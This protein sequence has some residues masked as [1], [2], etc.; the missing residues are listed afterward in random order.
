MVP[1]VDV[2]ALQ[3]ETTGEEAVVKIRE[4]GYSRVILTKGRS[5]D[6][7]AGYLYAKDFLAD[8]DAPKLPNLW[9]MRRDI[10]FVPETM[11]LLDLMREMQKQQTPIAVVVDE[12]GGSSGIVSME[13]L[14]E[15][16]VGEIRDEMDEE[17]ATRISKVQGAESTWDVD[18]RAQMQDLR[19][20]GVQVDDEE[21]PETVGTVVLARLGRLPRRG[22][23]VNL[24]SDATAEVTS[25]SRR[26]V[27]GVRVHIA[28][29]EVEPAEPSR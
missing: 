17:P 21:A 12:Y 10:L 7:V 8:P 5:L 13:D 6:E 2:F 3:M 25:V 1:S 22:D 16:I 4:Q 15:E 20:I 9:T 19:A 28:R 29:P 11:S 24:G 26:R 18:A 23:K 27:T 14:L